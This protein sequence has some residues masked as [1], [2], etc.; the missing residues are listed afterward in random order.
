[1]DPEYIFL[2]GESDWL[3]RDVKTATCLNDSK[4][5]GVQTSLKEKMLLS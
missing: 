4:Q 2:N 3:H 5:S 1:M